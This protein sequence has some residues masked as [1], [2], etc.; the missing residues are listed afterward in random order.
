MATPLCR[1][2]ANRKVLVGR[3]WYA[4][5]YGGVGW[6]IATMGTVLDTIGRNQRRRRQSDMKP[7]H[8]SRHRASNYIDRSHHP[9][10][11][12]ISQQADWVS[13]DEFPAATEW[14]DVHEE[15]LW[16]V[17]S[18]GQTPRFASRLTRSAYQRDRTFAEIAVGYFLETKC[19]L[20][21][22]EWE[23]HGEARTKGEFR[24]ARLTKECSSK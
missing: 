24:L 18:K 9:L 8:Y 19:S 6:Y 14:A 1:G 22:I 13:E 10:L 21:I 23:P 3:T 15:W 17:E 2:K 16:F 5:A 12:G 11:Y 7:T 4:I 20:P